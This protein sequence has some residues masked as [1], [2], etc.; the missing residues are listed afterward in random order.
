MLKNQYSNSELRVTNIANE[1]GDLL[2]V[3]GN[4]EYEF[5]TWN[6]V[7]IT[8]TR[9]DTLDSHIA[10]GGRGEGGY[11]AF[12][13]RRKG[14]YLALLDVIIEKKLDEPLAKNHLQ[15]EVGLKTQEKLMWDWKKS[16][17]APN[18]E[19]LWKLSVAFEIPE[20]AKGCWIRFQM[21]ARNG[22]S[23]ICKNFKLIDLDN[24]FVALDDET[25]SE[26][27]KEYFNDYQLLIEKAGRYI[28]KKIRLENVKYGWIYD[29]IDWHYGIK[30]S[31]FVIDMEKINFLFNMKAY[32]ILNYVAEYLYIK[33]ADDII[34]DLILREDI[35][36]FP[37]L[38][39]EYV[40]EYCV[41]HGKKYNDLENFIIEKQTLRNGLNW[42]AFKNMERKKFIPRIKEKAWIFSVYEDV[43]KVEFSKAEKINGKIPVFVYWNSG[44]ENAPF[45]IK[46]NVMLMKKNLSDMFELHII[47]DTNLELY[48]QVPAFGKNLHENF[49]AHYSDYIRLM[50][51]EKWGGI[52][53]DSSAMI[54]PDFSFCFEEIF[55]HYMG[56]N[57]VVFPNYTPNRIGNWFIAV[58]SK[59]NYGIQLLLRVI[60]LY[61]LNYKSLSEYFMFHTFWEVLVQIDEKL[62]AQWEAS[63]KISAKDATYILNNMYKPCSQIDLKESYNKSPIHKLT[64]KYDKDKVI[65]GSVFASLITGFFNNEIGK[66][67]EEKMVSNLRIKEKNSSE[68]KNVSSGG[69]T[70]P[71]R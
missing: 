16:E 22:S 25:S 45:L 67:E 49:I 9:E 60:N 71:F 58:M 38:F 59:H 54:T 57:A 50:L 26:K 14:K 70:V 10:P 4:L 46:H 31:D 40:Y 55:K 42:V 41:C 8:N 2:Y 27:L 56:T 1:L 30:D 34:N 43:K 29:L 28:D 36:N 64:Y 48:L 32:E 20:N 51:L 62:R 24:P 44:L 35:K 5:L 13:M 53:I 39:L 37:L 47:D 65:A 23:V 11:F 68:E 61:W 63:P 52:W 33:E 3:R 66:G 7:R 17:Q 12:N 19:G 6:E 21:G 69:G 15:I 18:M